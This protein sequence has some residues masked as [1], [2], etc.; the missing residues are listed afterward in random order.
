[1]IY[2]RD[3]DADQVG[4]GTGIVGPYDELEAFAVALNEAVGFSGGPEPEV[5]L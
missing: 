1:M 4:H 2:T 5:Q 3:C